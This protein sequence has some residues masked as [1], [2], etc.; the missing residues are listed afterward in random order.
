MERPN[1]LYILADDLGWA[2][3][4][5]HGAPISTPHIDG[6][7]ADGVELTHHYVC[8]V[9]TPTRASLLTGRYPSRFGAHATGPSNAPV[10]PDDTFTLARMLRDAG[11]ETGLFGKWHLGSAPAF[12]PNLFGFQTAYG[13]LAGGV[14]PYSHR[15]KQGDF[16]HTWHAN[17]EPVDETG[18][19]TDLIVREAVRWIETR[20]EPWF[21][22]VPFTAVHVPVKPTQAWLSRYQSEHFD[23]DPLKDSSYKKYAAYAS[24]MDHGVGALLEALERLCQRDNTLVVFAS[25]NGASNDCPLHE[26]DKYPGWQEAYPRL[27]SN[28]PLR[29]VKA[30]LYEGGIRTPTVANWRGHLPATTM[31][32]PVHM[33]DWMPTL[34]RLLALDPAPDVD[35]CWDGLDIWP[36]IDGTVRQPSDRCLFWNFAAG[37]QW[38]VRQGGW[39]LIVHD[40]EGE[41]RVELFHIDEDPYEQ[42]DL[43]GQK[44]G[45]VGDLISLINEQRK[46][47]DTA[48][49][50]EVDSA[51]VW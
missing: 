17:G 1:I 7:A 29:G 43:A 9:C 22:Y 25:D 33:V 16:S 30:Q 34:A 12:G 21:C 19:A 5:M 27:G 32:H 49:R 40:P 48:K 6:L 47:D 37:R 8:P 50:P 28:L 44:P 24:H 3:V 10:L 39:K 35:P 36:L 2:D 51:Q 45:L 20:T 26:T 11:Y 31:E 18:H 23:D 46:L 14:D 13:S 38:A 15:Y 41:R 42:E 4:G